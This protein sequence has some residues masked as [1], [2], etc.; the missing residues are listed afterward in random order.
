VRKEERLTDMITLAL[1]ILDIV[2][3]SISAMATEIAVEV[4]ES[5]AVDLMKITVKDNGR[6]MS[7]DLLSR[8]T[9]PFVTTRKTRRIGLGIPLLKY[10]ANLAGGDLEIQSGEGIGTTLSATLK[11]QHPDRQPLGDLA[12][13][14]TILMTANPGIDFL[15]THKTDMGEYCFSSREVMEYLG[16]TDFSDVSLLT[17]IREMMNNNLEDIGASG[18][19]GE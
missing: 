2:Q 16:I 7:Q 3:N 15:Y 4:T 17:D 5:A 18:F 12:G 19:N 1:N 9:D 13:M 6:G 11:L 10:H 8:V 14:M